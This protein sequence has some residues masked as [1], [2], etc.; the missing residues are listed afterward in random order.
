MAELFLPGAQ[1]CQGQYQAG[2]L[3]V[4]A[5]NMFEQSPTRQ[6]SLSQAPGYSEGMLLANANHFMCVD[7]CAFQHNVRRAE[8]S[9]QYLLHKLHDAAT[10]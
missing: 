6:G 10:V 2:H 8:E 4:D 3:R 7:Q 5:Q 9:G 1:V